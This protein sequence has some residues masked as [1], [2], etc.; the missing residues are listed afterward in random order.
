MRVRGK[1]RKGWLPAFR[2]AALI[3]VMPP[4]SRLRTPTACD[5]TRP[6]RWISPTSAAIRRAGSSVGTAPC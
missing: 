3:K 4:C 6:G 1:G 2:D 5:A